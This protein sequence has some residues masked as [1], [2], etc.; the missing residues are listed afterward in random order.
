VAVTKIWH[1]PVQE[2]KYSVS[3]AHFASNYL[4]WHNT[5]L[6]KRNGEQNTVQNAK[7]F[8][9]YINNLNKK[10]TLT[11]TSFQKLGAWVYGMKYSITEVVKS[12]FNHADNP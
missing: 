8:N 7:R 3:T 1:I 5:S 11:I 4:K 12:A 9:K 6:H 2:Y 10:H